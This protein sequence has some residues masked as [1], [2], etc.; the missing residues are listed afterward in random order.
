MTIDGLTRH[1]WSRSLAWHVTIAAAMLATIAACGSASPRN[2]TPTQPTSSESAQSTS[3]TSGVQTSAVS[4]AA[5]GDSWPAGGH[6]GGC[7]TFMGRFA[8]GLGALTGSGVQF[9]DRT[10][11]VSGR[12]ARRGQTS[13]SLLH[14]LRGDRELRRDVAGGDVIAIH[15]G[16]N[17]VDDGALDAFV[18]GTCGGVDG[19]ECVRVLGQAWRANFDAILTEIEGLRAGRP[20]AIRLV[21]AEEVFI[22]D[23]DV[24]AQY[25]LAFGRTTGTAIIDQLDSAMCDAAAVHHAVCVDVRSLLNG[26]SMDQPAD[27][28]N[29]P[30]THQ[31][32]AD[33]LLSHG[34][35]ELSIAAAPSTTTSS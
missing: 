24:V 18:A 35:G 1:S 17:D 8:D 7:R 31:A 12:H 4:S 27:G 10:Q 25:G 32:I 26:P 9:V 14:D 29:S 5:L 28:E 20:T 23:P 6:C 21:A 33:L 2:S 11:A 3:S 16:L 30:E 19:L 22:S 15:T 34:L 13:G